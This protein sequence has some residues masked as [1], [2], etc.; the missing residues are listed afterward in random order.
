MP[1][2]LTKSWLIDLVFWLGLF[3]L[4]W[5]V[6]WRGRFVCCLVAGP[7][8][9]R[10]GLWVGACVDGGHGPR[11]GTTL[12]ENTIHPHVLI[13]GCS[14][15]SSRLMFRHSVI[16]CS[17]LSVHGPS[18]HSSSVRAGVR[19]KE[20]M[21]LRDSG[22]EKWRGLKNGDRLFGDAEFTLD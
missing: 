4:R 8:C 12:S 21:L 9:V 14:S 5:P 6:G 2:L 1:W 22:S 19:T 3:V 13:L 7:A 16:P 18:G 15:D 20:R 17:G 10:R 11:R